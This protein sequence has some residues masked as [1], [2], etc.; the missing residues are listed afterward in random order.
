M[1]LLK[2][3]AK[4]EVEVE[5]EAEAEDKIFNRGM[6]TNK[7]VMEEDNPSEEDGN[8]EVEVEEEEE[9]HLTKAQ[10]SENL[11]WPAKPQIRIDAITAMS[12]DISSENAH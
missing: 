7:M 4:E 3:E 11:E 6:T 9:E 8:L 1:S 5:E 12:Q 2:A 10:T